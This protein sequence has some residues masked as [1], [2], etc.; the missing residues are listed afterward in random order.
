MD[1]R[2]GD[3]AASSRNRWIATLIVAGLFA[4]TGVSRVV[5]GGAM[6]SGILAILMAAALLRFRDVVRWVL[7][8]WGALG[9][10]AFFVFALTYHLTLPPYL[11]LVLSAT[12][13]LGYVLLLFGEIGRI[14]LFA[15]IGVL[16]VAAALVP[17]ADPVTSAA[18][19]KPACEQRVTSLI[20]RVRQEARSPVGAPVAA[21]PPG[22]RAFAK[23][24]DEA[25]SQSARTTLVADQL[26]RR[27]GACAPLAKRLVRLNE[28][29]GSEERFDMLLR[30]L[31]EGLNECGCGWI[32]LDALEYVLV[33]S[34][35]PTT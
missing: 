17:F 7:V 34:L 22:A 14:R 28:V 20:E 35:S 15:G 25:K 3:A 1:T 2:P 6:V 9:S 24:F 32:D 13:S 19:S 23:Q 27:A 11:F 30:S 29:Q 31:D 21:P 8:A 4:A 12:V 16:G 26:S 18:L 33:R 10:L 5:G